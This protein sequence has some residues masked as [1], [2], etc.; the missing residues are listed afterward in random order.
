VI[1]HFRSAFHGADDVWPPEVDETARLLMAFTPS[2]VNFLEGIVV[3]HGRDVTR[4]DVQRFG[5]QGGQS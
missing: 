3:R 5:G 4:V 1:T 2:A